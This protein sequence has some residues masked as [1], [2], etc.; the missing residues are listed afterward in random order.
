MLLPH[1][2][3]SSPRATRYS[4]WSGSRSLKSSARMTVTAGW[5]PGFPRERNRILYRRTPMAHT[6]KIKVFVVDGQFQYIVKH[7]NL[8]DE[9]PGKHVVQPP[10]EKVKWRN[11]ESA[12]TLSITFKPGFWPFKG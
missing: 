6:H 10:K 5:F 9:E 1:S 12:G 3:S 7:S 4:R 11:M 2:K 8:S